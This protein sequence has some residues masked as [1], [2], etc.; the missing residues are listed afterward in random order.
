MSVQFLNL[1]KKFENLH[2]IF[3]NQYNNIF[4]PYERGKT[5]QCVRRVISHS[6][7]IKQDVCFVSKQ[8]QNDYISEIYNYV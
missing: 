4:W 6:S 8:R 2:C 5:I 7:A 1:S 3:I